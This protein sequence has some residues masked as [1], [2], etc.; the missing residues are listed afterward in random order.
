[1][2]STYSD[3]YATVEQ[4]LQ[5][6]EHKTD[7]DVI[8]ITDHDCLDGALKARDIA[9]KGKY[10]V[11]LITG[12][13]VSTR[14]GHLLALNLEQPIPAGLHMA[15]TI[16]AIHE[17]RGL[18]VVAHPLSQWCPSATVD[19]LISLS[20]E[21]PDAIEVHNASFAGIGSNA[22]AR[23]MN[24]LRLGWTQ[25]GSS[26]AHTLDAIGSSFT[27]FLGSRAADLISTIRH[28]AAIAL[29]GYWSAVALADYGYHKIRRSAPHVP[30]KKIANR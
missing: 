1:M 15:E 28:R 23:A 27:I 17:Q 13:E 6:V 3:G 29:G 30:K 19:T 5:H 22:R 25:I 7:L 10:R 12:V 20:Q 4:I 18:A 8:A 24:N 16:H 14:D 9:A 11:E 26:D 2:H 21:P